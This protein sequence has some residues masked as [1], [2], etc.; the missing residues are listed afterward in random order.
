MMTAAGIPP[1]LTLACFLVLF[2]I[3]LARAPLTRRNICFLLICLSGCFLHAD[4]LYAFHSMSPRTALWVSRFD[5]LFLVYL[6]PLYIQFFHD[7]LQ[8]SHRQWLV[9]AAFAYAVLL[10]CV[11]PTPLYIVS[12]KRHWFGLFAEAGML[13]P[14][15]GIGG[16]VVTVYV[17]MLLADAVKK[18]ENNVRKKQLKYVIFG[19]GVMGLMNGLNIVPILGYSLY[20][21]GNLSFIPLVIFYVGLFK[22]D[23]LDTGHLVKK[24]LVY[25]VVTA[26][27]TGLYALLILMTERV[28]ENL[29]I[30]KTLTFPLLFFVL[31]TLVIGPL[32]SR[33]QL[34]IDRLWFRE[35]YDFQKTIK[36]T[37]QLIVSVLDLDEIGEKLTESIVSTIPV[38]HCSLYVR[39]RA[40]RGFSRLSVRGNAYD[41]TPEQIPE[42]CPIVRILEAYHQPIIRSMDMDRLPKTYVR[43]PETDMETL[44]AGM[45]LPMEFKQR[46]N[47]FIVLGEKRSGNAFVQEDVDLLVTLA[48]QSA[49]AVENAQAYQVIED[50]N[51]NLERKVLDRTRALKTALSEKERTQELLIRSESLAAIGQLVAG[52]AHELNN[53]LAGAK[54]LVQSTVEDLQERMPREHPD[55]YMIDDLEFADR[56]LKRAGD[57][58][59]SLLSLSRQTTDYTEIVNL[60]SVIRDA[61]RILFNQFKYRQIEIVENYAPDLPCVPGN[62]SELGQVA[63]NIIKNAVQAVPDTHGRIELITRNHFPAGEIVFECTDNGHGVPADIRRDVFKPFFTTKPVGEG[64]GL[65]LYISHEIVRRHGGTLDLDEGV[66][67]GARFVLRFPIRNGPPLA[68]S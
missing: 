25:S 66:T 42:S 56:E 58:V 27:L 9:R 68:H 45:V 55:W 6:L 12:L 65:G 41:V 60:N 23:L 20:P 28:F 35:K 31:I 36:Q 2:G 30:T 34:L 29:Q 21:P 47:G 61:L 22:H 51:K 32:K 1:L 10:M 7:Y 63:V 37:S 64:T 18:A 46:L 40:D 50:L 67:G 15:F 53:P 3:T 44:H 16:V 57:I 43:D 54:S 38:C 13:Y 5:H 48:G 33:V 19:F 62:F 26:G 39:R 52:V 59:S 11:V 49:M 17:L 8:I 14:L 24:G 4:I